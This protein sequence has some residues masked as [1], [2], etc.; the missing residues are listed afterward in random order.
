MNFIYLGRTNAE[1]ESLKKVSFK[2][3]KHRVFMTLNLGSVKLS[4]KMF[5]PNKPGWALYD[6]NENQNRFAKV[7]ES[8]AQ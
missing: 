2:R 7:F 5:T 8:V 3:R 6:V 1:L 4:N